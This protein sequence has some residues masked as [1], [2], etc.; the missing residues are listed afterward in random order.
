MVLFQR[1]CGSAQ[2]K[3]FSRPNFLWKK[4]SDKIISC[5][6][7]MIRAKWQDFLWFLRL[8]GY[9]GIFWGAGPIDEE[10]SGV[11]F[12]QMVLFAPPWAR[13]M[14]FPKEASGWKARDSIRRVCLLWQRNRPA[15]S[16]LHQR[17]PYPAFGQ[18]SRMN[19]PTASPCPTR[20]KFRS[21][22][23]WF[24]IAVCAAG[25]VC[26]G[27]I[28][29]RVWAFWITAHRVERMSA[30]GCNAG[31][32]YSEVSGRG[33]DSTWMTGWYYHELNCV[34]MILK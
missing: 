27:R 4:G 1:G 18:S 10:L 33:G 24:N 6:R 34:L 25:R 21:W 11:A 9:W 32:I 31:E 28:S 20:R 23:P 8:L 14:G 2:K 29:W 19:R 12:R 30:Q 26:L 22:C 7:P 13:G 16:L 15:Q 3:Y 5:H 17:K